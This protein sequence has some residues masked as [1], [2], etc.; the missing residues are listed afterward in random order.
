M[1]SDIENK[2]EEVSSA[3]EFFFTSSYSS[4]FVGRKI[5]VGVNTSMQNMLHIEGQVW[6]QKG[7]PQI[8]HTSN[9]KD[10]GTRIPAL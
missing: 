4:G 9:G 10:F 3:V 8:K 5:V 6:E 1:V 2:L 7:G